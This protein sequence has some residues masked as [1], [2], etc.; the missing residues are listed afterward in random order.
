MIKPTAIRLHLLLPFVLP[1]LIGC[2][3]LEETF[4]ATAAPT[5][6]IPTRAESEGGPAPVATPI[7]TASAGTTEVTETGNEETVRPTET[8]TLATATPTATPV[9]DAAAEWLDL[10]NLPTINNDLAYVSAETLWLW[11]H[12]NR[13]VV[14]LFKPEIG[15]DRFPAGH[16]AEIAA[17]DFSA[18]GNR[19]AVLVRYTIPLE[20]AADTDSDGAERSTED[21][22][23]TEAEGNVDVDVEKEEE[24][25]AESGAEFDIFFID[26]VSREVWPLVTGIQD[27]VNEIALSPDQ[28]TLLF[29]TIYTP[30]ENERIG[31][32]VKVG[33]PAGDGSAP[34]SIAQCN[35]ACTDIVWRQ[36]SELYLFADQDG[37]F[38]ANGEA[39]SVEMALAVNTEIESFQPLS[40]APNDR[41]FL[42]IYWPRDWLQNEESPKHGVFDFPTGRLIDVGNQVATD[43]GFHLQTVWMAD[44]RAL[45][46]YAL[47]GQGMIL[48]QTQRIDFDDNG[49]AA[50]DEERRLEAVPMVGS[51]TQHPD[52]RFTFVRPDFSDRQ[53]AG[54]YRLTS[55]SE[56]PERIN[57]LPL[58]GD[59][60]DAIW[61]PS[62][63]AAVIM[64]RFSYI[65][66]ADG[67]LYQ[68]EQ[69]ISLP[70]WLPNTE[71]A[72]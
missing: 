47:A 63:T 53:A 36:D 70:H 20:P 23:P 21:A 1:V 50:V 55:F 51:L 19:A 43:E 56:E 17:I 57:P 65:A 10:N 24:K 49:E 68:F 27:D 71:V 66:A 48:L 32:L 16:D 61:S 46:T 3:G 18:D 12:Q 67:A 38:F 58:S 14:P 35:S 60:P 25:E 26:T 45:T 41:A 7:P 22:E 8:D 31:T 5:L 40:W 9:L 39:T 2:S 62:G 33:T 54:L 69:P 72:R 30:L 15:L 59:T 44:A 13:Q 52:G 29:A 28:T 64:H 6:Y 37:I 4:S 42:L 11:T 34:L